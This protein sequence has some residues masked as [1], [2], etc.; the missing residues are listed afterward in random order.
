MVFF[1]CT[2]KLAPDNGWG[3]GRWVVT[4]MKGVPVQQSGGRRDAHISFDV[5]Q[6]QF[7]GNGGCNQINGTYTI[8]SSSIAFRDVASTKMA[9]E[10][11]AFEQTF[12]ETLA[13]VNKYELRDDQ[14]LL[15]NKRK[16]VLVLRAK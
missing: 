5:N 3:R 9:C 1:N 13:T 6:K 11:L 8:G 4:E 15:K 14:L 7:S 10:D 12:L 2:P 16:V